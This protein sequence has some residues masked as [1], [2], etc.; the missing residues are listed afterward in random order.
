MQRRIR[1]AE[2]SKVVPEMNFCNLSNLFFVGFITGFPVSLWTGNDFIGLAVGASVAGIV[3]V[4][5][6]IKG[7]QPACSIEP[8]DT[9]SADH[10]EVVGETATPYLTM[11]QSAKEQANVGTTNNG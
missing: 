4:Y 11:K 2:H 8:S 1:G 7:T 10:G 3:A 5:W 9:T 6:W